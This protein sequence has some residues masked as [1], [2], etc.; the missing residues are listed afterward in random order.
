MTKDTAKPRD[1]QGQDLEL[2][3]NVFNEQCSAIASPYSIWQDK[4]VA[5]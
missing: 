4:Q 3:A 5:D 2:C 1:W